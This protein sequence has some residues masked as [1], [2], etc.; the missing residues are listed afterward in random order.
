LAVQF[1]GIDLDEQRLRFRVLGGEHQPL[2]GDVEKDCS[3][4]RFCGLREL[5]AFFG[6]FAIIVHEKRSSLHCKRERGR[7][8]QP[9]APGRAVPVIHDRW[10]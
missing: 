1:L 2:G 6:A 7:V 5:D 3:L 4:M 10:G 8:S 9:P